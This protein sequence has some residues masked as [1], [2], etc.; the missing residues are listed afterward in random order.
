MVMSF[1]RVDG[2]LRLLAALQ[3]ALAREDLGE[4]PPVRR[5]GVDLHRRARR[6]LD[7]ARRER[8]SEPFGQAVADDRL[9]AALD[10]GVADVSQ[11][12]VRSVLRR[13]QVGVLA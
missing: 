2:D 12:R 3:L 8:H 13:E 10:R 1:E 7:R 6:E 4:H 9:G 5:G 11:R